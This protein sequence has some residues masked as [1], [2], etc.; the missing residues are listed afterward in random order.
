[1]TALVENGRGEATKSDNSTA[2]ATTPKISCEDDNVNEHA[3]LLHEPAQ[4]PEV[5]SGNGGRRSHMVALPRGSAISV[6]HSEGGDIEEGSPQR[7]MTMWSCAINLSKLAFGTSL[8]FVPNNAYTC[9]YLGFPLLITAVA[10]F[11]TITTDAFTQVMEM[12]ES[13]ARVKGKK[14]LY[15]T[16]EAP[17]KDILGSWAFVLVCI[18]QN[19]AMFLGPAMNMMLTNNSLIAMYPFWQGDVWSWFNLIVAAPLCLFSSLDKFSVLNSAGLVG[20]GLI[21]GGIF[22]ASLDSGI[23]GLDDY[24]TKM[25]TWRED[26]FNREGSKTTYQYDGGDVQKDTISAFGTGVSDFVFT[27]SVLIWGF[28]FNQFTAYLRPELK[29]NFLKK[30][31]G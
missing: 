12:S 17:Y 4:L 10:L 25:V 26:W 13:D 8:L 30:I 16:V 7:T 3:S 27:A 2:S 23:S 22:A 15:S 31:F 19:A 24:K 21:V 5:F 18:L 20:V 29:K 28:G 11:D 6:S 14:V 9:G 1:M